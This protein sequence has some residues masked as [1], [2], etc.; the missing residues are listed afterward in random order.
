MRAMR[1]IRASRP[2]SP[3]ALKPASDRATREPTVRSGECS[4]RHT[5]PI[6][7]CAW[8][9]ACLAGRAMDRP[10]AWGEGL[11]RKNVFGVIFDYAR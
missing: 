1:S 11:D 4:S 5:L 9:L 2:K 7:P 10:H 6:A 3:W 8:Y